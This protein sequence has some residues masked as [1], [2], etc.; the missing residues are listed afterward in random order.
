MLETVVTDVAA[1]GEGLGKARTAVADAD[2]ATQQI[3]ARAA[4]SGLP[5]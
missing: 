3:A 4:G 5:A 1:I 2:Q